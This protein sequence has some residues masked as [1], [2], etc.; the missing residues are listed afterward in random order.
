VEPDLLVSGK[1][2]G[3]GFPVSACTGRPEIM[4]SVQ[5]GGLGG[6]FGGNPV[7]CSAALAQFPLIEKGMKNVPKVNAYMTKRLKEMQSR[8]PII[9]DVRGMGAMM[10]VELVSD[11]KAKTPAAKETKAVKGA[12]LKRGMIL[13][14][15]GTFDNVIRLHPSMVM[16]DEVLEQAMDIL[17]ASMEEGT[18]Q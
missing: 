16:P 6:T 5:V 9:G 14:T 13:L 15:C 1:G 2:I 11:P 8:F 17:E 3:G 10:A 7:A 4:D 18:K 12:A